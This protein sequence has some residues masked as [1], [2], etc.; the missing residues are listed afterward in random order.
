MPHPSGDFLSDWGKLQQWLDEE[1]KTILESLD[2][3]VREDAPKYKFSVLSG[4]RQMIEEVRGEMDKIKS[5]SA[6]G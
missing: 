4:R 6:S 3:L 2:R 1:Q 5:E